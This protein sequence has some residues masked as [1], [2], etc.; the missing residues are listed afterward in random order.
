[1]QD[2]IVKF[3][4]AKLAKEKG[5]DL[6]V[7][8]TWDTYKGELLV[9]TPTYNESKH[10]WNIYPDG[11]SAPTQSLLQRWLREEHNIYISVSVGYM[12]HDGELR[13]VFESWLSWVDDKGAFDETDVILTHSKDNK[14][15]VDYY[16]LTY[17]EALEQSLIE[18]LKLIK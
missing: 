14:Y 17:E 16:E 8:C 3:D 1:M 15:G 2:E 6:D 4:I 18:A 7:N 5:F 9:D 12:T 10:N 13:V 11:H